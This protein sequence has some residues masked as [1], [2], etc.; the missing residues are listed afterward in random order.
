MEQEGIGL[1]FWVENF[2]EIE[3]VFYPDG[4]LEDIVLEPQKCYYINQKALKAIDKLYEVIK[5]P[6]KIKG[7]NNGCD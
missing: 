1:G 4:E 6:N 3:I 5:D 2:G 7:D